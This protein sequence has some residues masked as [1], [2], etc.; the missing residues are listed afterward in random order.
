MTMIELI[1]LQTGVA[2]TQHLFDERSG[3]MKPWTSAINKQPVVGPI[4][5]TETGLVGD[6][7]ANRKVHGG[8]DKALLAYCGVHYPRWR[9]IFANTIPD[10]LSIRDGL[11]PGAFGEN[12][13]FTGLA[14]PDVC[15]GDRW[16]L[17]EV[18]VEV[19]Q[20]RQPC[21]NLSRRWNRPSLVKEVIANGWTGWYLRVITPGMLSAGDSVSLLERP[22]PDWPI[23]RAHRAMYGLSENPGD[24]AELASLPV[25]SMAWREELLSK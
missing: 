8:V 20:P 12:L 5:V 2:R 10:A 14:E 24:A 11:A 22:H 15:I 19:S 6:M 9:E 25:L 23:P 3:K 1:S 21:S 4:E 7:Q 13:T 16:Q 18:V 17:G